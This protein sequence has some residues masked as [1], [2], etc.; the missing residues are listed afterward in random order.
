MR[1][2]KKKKEPIGWCVSVVKHGTEHENGGLGMCGAPIYDS[3]SGHVCSL[4]HGGGTVVTQEELEKELADRRANVAR[5]AREIRT[6]A[7]T[8]GFEVRDGDR[9]T[10]MYHGAKLQIAPYNSVELDGGIYS[11]SL[12]PGDDP[13]EQWDR[14][15]G[16]LERKALEKARTKLATFADELRIAKERAGG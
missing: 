10:V 5:F 16:Y 4:G 3:P 9:L 7:E 8:A 1:R 6:R 12:L 14:I 15:H 11:R 13:E 2:R